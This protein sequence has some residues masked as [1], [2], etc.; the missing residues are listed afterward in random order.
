MTFDDILAQVLT[1]LQQ[2]G[3]VSYGALKRRFGLDDAYLDDLK[4]ELID[5]RR[6]AVDEDGRV[7]VWTGT[8]DAPPVLPSASPPSPARQDIP[9]PPGLVPPEVLAPPEAER[10]Q[11]TVLVCDL[12]GSTALAGQL[13]PEDLLAVLQAYQT[14]CTE[15]IQRFGGQVAQHLGD[16]LLVYFGYPQ[17]HD[18]DAQRAVRAGLSIIDA[19][20]T[21]NRTLAQERGVRLALRVGIHTGLVV[22]GAIGGVGRQAQLAL[23]DTPLMAARLQSLA[24]PDTVVLSETT[25]RLVQGYFTWQPLGNHALADGAQPLAVYQVLG[26]SGAH[27]R[28]DVASPQALTPLVGRE[29][30]VQLLLERWARVQEGLGQVVLVSGEAGIGK[31]RLVQV[32]KAHLADTP[33][34]RWEC[35][36]S[37]YYQHTALYPLIDLWERALHFQRD[38]PPTAKL[39]RLKDALAQYSLPLDETVPLLAALLSLP[40]PPERYAPLTLTPQRQR[41]KTLETLLALTLERATRHPVILVMEDLHWVDPSTLEFLTLLIEQSPTTAIFTLLTYRP[42][43]QPPW[44]VRTHLTPLVV[45]RLPESQAGE[46]VARVTGGKPLPPEV[47]QQIVARTDGV[48]L[49]VEELT[50]TVLETGVLQ[51]QPEHYTLRGPLPPRA[52][53]ATLHDALMARLDRL[54]AVKVVAQLGATLGRT[55]AYDLLRAVAPLE[56]GILQHG[57]QQLV[58]AELLYQRGIPPQATYLF[59]HALIQEAAYQSLLKSTRQQYHQR[60][61]QVL[62]AQFPET[63][64]TQP[65]VLAHHCTEAGLGA[66]AVDYWQRAGQR[67]LQRSA[68]VEAIHHCTRALEL[69]ATLPDTPE[70]RRQEL[71]VHTALGP[72]LIATKG[73]AAPDVERAYTRARELCQQMGE[74]PQLFPVLWGLWL[75]Y[76]VRASALQTTRELAFQLLEMAQRHAD[77]ALLLEAHMACGLSLYHCG[78]PAA[79]LRRLEAGRTLYDPQQ[80]QAHTFLYGQD[81][82]V[83][84]L[85]Y[86]GVALWLLGYPDQA[87][88]RIHDALTLAQTLVHPFNIAFAHFFAGVLHPL[89]REPHPTQVQAEALLA[90]AAQHD[91]AYWRAQG[92]ILHGWALAAQGQGEEGLAQIRQGLA[93]HQTIGS[94]IAHTC[95]LGLLADGCR[96][97]GQPAAGLAAVAEALALGERS[98]EQFYTAELQRLRGELLLQAGTWEPGSRNTPPP[99]AVWGSQGGETEDCLCQALAIARQQ[100]ARSLELRAA[101][102]L[103]RLWQRQ[104]KRAEARQ[105]LAPVYGWF[106]EGFD[107]ADLQDAQA[108]LATL[109]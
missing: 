108:L 60:I 33:H 71:E 74:T 106:T 109:A 20:D 65:E 47:V 92:M 30:E 61:A 66:L 18:D 67:T 78:E 44:S 10:R 80:H 15:V 94:A 103:A 37:P 25:A 51:E 82:G 21:L 73:Y 34:T 75:F 11:L 27:S 46:M 97:G 105:L 87:L 91:F 57:L 36:G 17:A 19:M 12:V 101:T 42:E 22:V 69:L 79:A 7:L 13:D 89:R 50:K 14:A 58:E 35:H 104:G 8:A 49:F 24:P 31:S 99:A 62:E 39:A 86:G 16:G 88:V 95:W 84:C 41:Q 40:L 54:A 98:G 2:Q 53:P 63:V 68:Y 81:P 1:L 48:P 6:L 4:A 43:F 56:E 100:Q 26:I 59:K 77:P 45:H 107:T 85:T 29:Q 52:I 23:G 76:L 83:A 90:L 72:A 96:T 102:S 70:R 38:E 93:I 32:V 64:E 28:L 9:F 5:A 3:R 55:F